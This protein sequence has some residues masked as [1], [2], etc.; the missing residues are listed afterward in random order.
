MSWPCWLTDSG[1]LNRKVITHPA[2]NLAQDRV[3]SPAETSI[4]TTMLCRQLTLSVCLLEDKIKTLSDFNGIF[5][6]I[7]MHS[8]Y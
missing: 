5:R 1:R 8:T 2:S 6:C 3:S 7:Y 4:L